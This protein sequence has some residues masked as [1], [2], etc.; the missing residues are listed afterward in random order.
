MKFPKALLA[1]TFLFMTSTE[2][3]SQNAR[4]T[5][6]KMSKGEQKAIIADYPYTQSLVE[7]AL[8]DK[9][10][11]ANFGKSKSKNGFNVYSAVTWADV[12][13]ADKLDVYVKT[14]EKKGVT[15]ITMLISRGYDNFLAA[16]ADQT[17]IDNL[18]GFLNNLNSGIISADLTRKIEDQ[19]KVLKSTEERCAGLKKDQAKLEGDKQKIEKSLEQNAEAQ[20]K[21]AA[22][23]EEVKVKLEQL[24]TQLSSN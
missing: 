4:E 8:E 15:T 5:I 2:A 16:P 20:K 10:S 7:K 18:K 21:C 13:P 12:A 11:K 23:S 19:N 14:A 24:K 17:Q 22:E 3:F 1:A 6:T 9:F